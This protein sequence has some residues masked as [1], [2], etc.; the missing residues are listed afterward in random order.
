MRTLS[1]KAFTLVE[2]LVVIAI[3]GILAA[4]LLTALSGAKRRAD[5]TLC[6]NNVRQLSHAMQQFVGDNHAYPL[7]NNVD[8][9]KGAYPNHY[10]NWTEALNHILEIQHAPNDIGWQLQGVWKCPAMRRPANWPTNMGY[11]DTSL[12]IQ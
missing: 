9:S 11:C 4:V 5:R 6:I 7:D 10:E 2:T 1:A 12:R 8:F 3:I